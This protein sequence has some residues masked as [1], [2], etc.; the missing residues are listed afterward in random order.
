MGEDENE[1]EGEGKSGKRRE[2]KL[3]VEEC[4]LQLP[5]VTRAFGSAA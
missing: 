5:T 3:S 2:P 4:S 1:E